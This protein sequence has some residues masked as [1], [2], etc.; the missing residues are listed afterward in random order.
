MAA[1]KYSEAIAAYGRAIDL[2]P[3]NPV[4]FSNRAAAWSQAGNHEKAI[5]D[6]NRAKEID[7]A[8]TKA[9]SRLG[10]AYFSTGRY[11]EA[12]SAYQ[13][14][15]ELEPSVSRLC[16]RKTRGRARGRDRARSGK[17]K[18]CHLQYRLLAREHRSGASSCMHLI[19]PGSSH[20]SLPSAPSLLSCQPFWHSPY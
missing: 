13:R 17:A 1:K 5:E 2:N 7:P 20:S 6:A 3:S 14:A 19:M 9:Y 12:V 4:Y 15:V 16:S 11:D 8:F 10:H 18:A